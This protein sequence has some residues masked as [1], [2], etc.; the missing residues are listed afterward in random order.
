MPRSKRTF[1]LTVGVSAKG[2]PTFTERQSNSKYGKS[3][4]IAWKVLLARVGQQMA[5]SPI[6]RRDFIILAGA[7]AAISSR[8]TAQSVLSG[9][10][11]IAFLSPA[12]EPGTPMYDAFRTG[13][14]R[15]GYIE[16]RNIVIERWLARTGGREEMA[17]LAVRA[18]GSRVNII[19][20]DGGRAADAARAATS[21]IPIIAVIGAD[22]VE[23]GW[24]A[25]LARPGGNLT[26]VTTYAVETT[27]KLLDLL[28]EL[29]PTVRR[30]AVLFASQAPATLR[31]IR[32]AAQRVGVTTREITVTTPSQLEH[33][34]QRDS[35]QDIGGIVVLADPLLGELQNL[36]PTVNAT[37][38]PAIYGE[39]KHVDAG[40]LMSYGVNLPDVFRRL[41]VY[42]DRVLK[43]AR[44]ADLPIERPSKLEFII[45]LRT[46]KAL[47][48][49]IPT[50]LLARA[51]DVIE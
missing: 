27:P 2:R 43:G 8:A 18:V 49:T 39:R 31:A 50:T 46:A 42:V 11:R 24:V 44:P 6:G 32:V 22:P 13:L 47:G 15:L 28:I 5:N 38:Q 35:L 30:L 7:V 17:T 33:A 29:A 20:A 14:R 10:P 12:S 40:G 23:R 48:L 34:L 4:A 9:P 45:N 16:G 25:S 37:R 41:A 51:D 36:V 1:A 19:V 3:I 21:T 26:G